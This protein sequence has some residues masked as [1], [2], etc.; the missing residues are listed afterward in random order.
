[1]FT[2]VFSH[3]ANPPPCVLQPDLVK[4][5]ITSFPM[6]LY[7]MQRGHFSV[8]FAGIGG[9]FLLKGCFQLRVLGKHVTWKCGEKRDLLTSS[10]IPWWLLEAIVDLISAVTTAVQEESFQ[11]VADVPSHKDQGFT[12]IVPRTDVGSKSNHSPPAFDTLTSNLY[13]DV[14]IS[15]FHFTF[16]KANNYLA[17]L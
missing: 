5:K 10:Q 7:E 15:F 12:I 11:Q 6:L 9:L 16:D 1:M 3:L 4:L 13:G 17:G 14:R 8:T 2:V